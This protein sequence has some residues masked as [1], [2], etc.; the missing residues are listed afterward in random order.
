MRFAK[1]NY[2]LTY[3]YWFIYVIQFDFWWWHSN[4]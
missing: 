3:S 2:R 1:K 4:L